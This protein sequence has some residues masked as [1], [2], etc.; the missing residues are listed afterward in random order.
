MTWS[1]ESRAARP[2]IEYGIER[3]ASRPSPA[4][5]CGGL[6]PDRSTP[7]SALRYGVLPYS[8]LESRQ[9]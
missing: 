7:F 8:V 1:R 5:A 3:P 6:D 9:S 2:E 4:G